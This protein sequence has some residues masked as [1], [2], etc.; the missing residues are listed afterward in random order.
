MIGSNTNSLKH[1]DSITPTTTTTAT[2]D[3]QND[4]DIPEDRLRWRGPKNPTP[5]LFSRFS[6]TGE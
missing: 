3:R 2:V 1:L 6:S 4:Q 5:L